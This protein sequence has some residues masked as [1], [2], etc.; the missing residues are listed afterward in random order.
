V[1]AIKKLTV[2]EML[3]AGINPKI[4]ERAWST[5]NTP[6]H[7]LI[8]RH[9]RELMEKI[10]AAGLNHEELV[11][12]LSQRLAERV[13]V[14]AG[15]I[16]TGTTTPSWGPSSIQTGHAAELAA[17][18]KAWRPAAKAPPQPAPGQKE[19]HQEVAAAIEDVPP[20]RLIGEKAWIHDVW[21]A[22]QANPA[23]R[24]L[25]LDEFKQL[26]LTDENRGKLRLGRADLAH[27]TNLADVAPSEEQYRIGDRIT[28]TFHFIRPKK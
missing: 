4:A 13:T 9:R 19:F 18:L 3:D 27:R 6:E 23:N 14:A 7:M 24:R 28:A 10:K 22:H 8:E 11:R 15:P 2:Q 1:V 25:T 16:A 5:V 12:Q 21:A 26:L 20:E 17:L